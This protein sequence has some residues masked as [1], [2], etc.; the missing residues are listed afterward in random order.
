M[1]NTTFL[2]SHE[3]HAQRELIVILGDSKITK[4]YL[5]QTFKSLN[6]LFF[7]SR[8][9][10]YRYLAQYQP[11]DSIAGK[12][13]ECQFEPGPIYD[14]IIA[15][16]YPHAEYHGKQ[17]IFEAL[18]HEMVHAYILVDRYGANLECQNNHIDE[19]GITGHGW[20]WMEKALIVEREAESSFGGFWDLG[21]DRGYAIQW[22][23]ERTTE[24]FPSADNVHRWE[25]ESSYIV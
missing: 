9:Q 7:S 5:T 10:K 8:L 1:H 4:P 11:A 13:A 3:L 25:F 23:F 16:A 17:S 18:L 15:V 20:P 12:V 14:F 21:R 22:A 6:D 2:S 19:V 24:E